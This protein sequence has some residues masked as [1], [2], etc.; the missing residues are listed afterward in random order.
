MIAMLLGLTVALVTAASFAR[1]G[2]PRVVNAPRF[3][4]ACGAVSGNPFE[5]AGLEY[6][7]A[8]ADDR[9]NFDIST[10]ASNPVMV[11]AVRADSPTTFAGL[12]VG[13]VLILVNSRGVASV[14]DLNELYDLGQKTLV[15]YDRRGTIHITELPAFECPPQNRPLV[16][17]C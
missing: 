11:A 3:D 12:Q 9:K 17:A 6:R 15:L 2:E 14:N 10:T 13:D 1:Y 8:T 4:A 5:S 7:F 16:A